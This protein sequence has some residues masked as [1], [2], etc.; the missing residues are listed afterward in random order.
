MRRG[1]AFLVLWLIIAA[2][3]GGIFVPA[4]PPGGVAWPYYLFV[5][6]VPVG[7]LLYKSLDNALQRTR[8]SRCGCNPSVP[9][10]GSLSWFGSKRVTRVMNA[11]NKTES[12]SEIRRRGLKLLVGGGLVFGAILFLMYWLSAHG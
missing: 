3:L 1:I 7:E 6:S 12:S 10:A 9:W 5:A 4:V 11:P 8:P 2:L